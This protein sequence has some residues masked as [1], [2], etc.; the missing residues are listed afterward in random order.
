MTIFKAFLI[1]FFS[2]SNL[3]AK[4][5][6]NGMAIMQKQDKLQTVKSEYEDQEIVLLDIKSKQKEKRG[7]KR[8]AQKTD[9]D[10]QRALLTFSQPKEIKG[11]ALLN[12][13]EGGSDN[14]WLYLH[15]LKKLQRIASGSKKKYFMGTDFTFADLDGEKLKENNYTCLKEETCA[16]DQTCFIIEATPLNK[17][18]AK[19][20]G[21]TKRT[22]YVDKVKFTTQKIDYYDKRKRLLKTV[23]YLKWVKEGN[24]WRPNLAAMNRHGK[25][26]TYIKVTKREIN[27]KINDLIFSKRYLEKEMHMK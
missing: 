10:N 17:E 5:S 3:Y 25:H 14:Q 13:R 7:L 11:A 8:Y 6:I 2:L 18:I 19:N 20:T 24:V 12:W 4:C 1:T 9:G 27:K 15:E 23:E 16:K 21:Y 26:K 22:L